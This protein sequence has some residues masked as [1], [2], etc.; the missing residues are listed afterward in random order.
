M[1]VDWAAIE[2]IGFLASGL[3]LRP[4]QV[5]TRQLGNT[6]QKLQLNEACYLALNAQPSGSL[7]NHGTTQS[8]CACVPALRFM[9]CLVA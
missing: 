6:Q 9:S 5:T 8:P 2:V 4:Y 3:H 7:A 1:Q